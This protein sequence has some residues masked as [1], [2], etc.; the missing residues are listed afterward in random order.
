MTFLLVLSILC[1]VWCIGGVVWLNRE[2]QLRYNNLHSPWQEAIKANN[3]DDCEH[4]NGVAKSYPLLGARVVLNP[5][6]WIR[7]WNWRP[8]QP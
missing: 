5:I 4:W 7:N 2:K 3:W 1:I 6:E 8:R